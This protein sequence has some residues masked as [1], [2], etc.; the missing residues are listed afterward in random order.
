MSSKFK[1]DC[2]ESNNDYILLIDVTT[3]EL[4]LVNVVYFLLRHP[5]WRKD[6]DLR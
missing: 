5:V 3:F 2:V 4:R 1:P 6:Y